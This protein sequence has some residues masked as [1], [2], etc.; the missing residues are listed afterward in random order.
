MWRKQS[1]LWCHEAAGQAAGLGVGSSSCCGAGLVQRDL[2]NSRFAVW[3]PSAQAGGARHPP[4]D[5]QGKV[6]TS[7]LE[8]GK[9][10]F[11]L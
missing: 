6:T 2:G 1:D 5:P 7:S 10:V 3:G 8:A 9:S 4:V 11:Q